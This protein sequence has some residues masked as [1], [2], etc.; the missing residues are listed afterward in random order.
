MIQ[1]RTT[2][3]MF[4]ANGLPTLATGTLL[5][6]LI[7]LGC[8]QLDRASQKTAL[9]KRFES[10]SQ[11]AEQSLD[12]LLEYGDDAHDF[13][14]SVHGEWLDQQTFLLDNRMH[15]G[16]AGFHIIVPMDTGAYVVLI[17]RGWVAWQADRN[18]L[19]ALPNNQGWQR[20]DGISS[21]PNP[22][23]FTLKDDD[24]DTVH[25]P[26][27]IQ[28]LDIEKSQALFSKPLLN[29]VVKQQHSVIQQWT[30]KFMGPDKHYGYAF[31]WFM[32]AITLLVFYIA[33]HTQR[34]QG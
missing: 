31:Q 23:I 18:T 12:A 3:W 19:P 16:K 26:F 25:W 2:H 34:R 10:R 21:I 5:V 29:V 1:L 17:N 9:L 28:K 20:V 8:W 33:I 22:D 30:P 15:N 13:P 24:Y 7:S 6:L 32:L 4:N 14:V 27:V 11:L